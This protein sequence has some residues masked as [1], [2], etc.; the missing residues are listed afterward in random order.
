MTDY[1]YLGRWNYLLDRPIGG[2]GWI[3]EAEAQHR[4]ETGGDLFS[5]V[6]SRVGDGVAPKFV[7]AASPSRTAPGF[8]ATFLNDAKS[9][10]EMI[11]YKTV[12]GRLFKWIFVNY[13]YPDETT[14]YQLDQST[15][16]VEGKTEP[17]GDGFLTINDKSKPTVGEISFRDI[18]VDDRWLPVPEFGDWENLTKGSFGDVHVPRLAQS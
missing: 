13:Q 9:I 12:N 10:V 17:N 6:D 5:I 8:R 11:D 16:I 15:M 1:R 3:D 2:Q 7:V 14:K 4:Y 18:P